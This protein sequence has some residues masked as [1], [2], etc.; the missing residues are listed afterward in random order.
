MMPGPLSSPQGYASPVGLLRTYLA[1]DR[2][3]A[4]IAGDSLPDRTSASLLFVDIAGFTRLTEA[5][6]EGLGPHRGVEELTGILN[7]VYTALVA[8]IHRYGGSVICFIG[9]AL[10]SCFDQDPGL[11][12]VACALR[13]QRAMKQ[14]GAIPVPDGSVISPAMKAAVASGPV[15][16]FLIGDP[17]IRLLDI[18]AGA[19]VDRV[20]EAEHIAGQGELVVAPE[21][22]KR[23]ERQLDIETWR[24]PFAVVRG[25]KGRVP[26]NPWPELPD[27]ALEPEQTRLFLLPPV[28]E[29]I[30]KGAGEF[31]AE[32]RPVV[33]LF[34]RF[35]GIDYD[36]DDLAG[37]KLGAFGKWVQRV[38]SRYGGHVLLL[39]T[40]DKGS[41]L[42]AVFGALA[43]HEND[44]ERAVAAA[45]TLQQPPS[46]LGFVTSV[47]IGISQGMARVG[48]YGGEARRTYGTLGHAVNLAAR[49]MQTA[50]P[51]EIRCSSS[52]YR[53][54][55]N[56][57]TFD[58]LPPVTVKG[59]R[60]PL[61]VYR[62][63]GTA[64]RTA[65]QDGPALVGRGTERRIIEHCL[66]N[67]QSTGR[68][69]LLL[70]G[71]AGM[72]KSRLADEIR[73]LADVESITCLLGAADSIEPHTPYRAW[74]DILQ[75]SLGLLEGMDPAEQRARARDRILSLDPTYVDRVALLNDV[76]GLGLPESRLTSGYD[77]AL[78]KESLAALVGELLLRETVSGRV[79]LIVEDAHWLDSLSW[80]LLLSVARSLAHRPLLLVVTHRP[81]AEPIPADYAAL[82]RMSG[83]RT[84]PLESLPPE[85]TLAL[86]ASRVGVAPGDLPREVASLLTERAAGNPFFAVELVGALLDRGLLAVKANTCTVVADAKTLGDSVPDSLEGVVLSRLD[87][88]PVEEQLTMRVAAVVGRS[89]LVRTLS[90]VYPRPIA[91]DELRGHLANTSARQLTTL[92]AEDPE[93]AYAFRH[94]ITQQVAYGTLLFAQRRE[95]HHDIATWYEETYRENLSPHHPL[96]AFHWNRAGDA[97][98][99]CRHT[100][101]AG[102]QAAKQYA[103]AEA[104]IYF[105]R[106]LELIDEMDRHGLSERRFDTLRNLARVNALL[107]SVEEERHDLEEL[108][109]MADCAEMAEQKGEVGLLWSDFHRRGGRF[110]EALEQAESALAA[111]RKSTS[112]VGEARAL[113]HAGS[114]LEGQGRFQD[115]RS[116]VEEALA[117]FRELKAPEGEAG[118]LKTLGIISARL[119]EFANA[120]TRFNEARAI[121][122]T[123][124]DKKGEADILGNLGAV[125]YHLG[126]YDETL[127]H[128][129]EAQQLFQEMGSR[130]GA[131][132]C[133]TNLGNSY[134]ALGAFNRGLEHHE[135]ALELYRQLEDVNGC[136]D[137]YSNLGNSH[138]AL[139]V[140][141]HPELTLRSYGETQGLRDAVAC[142]TE[143]LALRSQIE[144]QAGQAVSLFNLGSARL[145]IGNVEAAVSDL[146]QS[147]EASDALG[148]GRLAMRAI[149]ALARASLLAGDVA[150]A[151]SRSQEAID[152]LG[153]RTF[154][155]ADEVHFTHFR[156]LTADGRKAQARQHLKV[157]HQL[158]LRQAEAI[159][160]ANRRREY[161]SAYREI[162]DAVEGDGRTQSDPTRP[163]RPA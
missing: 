142:Y 60:R 123:L 157:A 34:L 132:K 53:S 29:R 59:V 95:L 148:L 82:T 121:F 7:L 28:Y 2:R 109:S 79:V 153:S 99:E 51:G 31:L 155:E 9:D 83:T 33:V 1:M 43:A 70:E 149:S 134:N 67:L 151:M 150:G 73:R 89:F 63:T 144:S 115:A 12:A 46:E 39:T 96:L 154:P 156:V 85:E 159:R 91:D 131:A 94:V 19:T 17:D 72:G 130:A 64:R 133:L 57:W 120:M 3:R 16:R 55:K 128:T 86:A 36:N 114:A 26:A 4:L 104:K 23:H 8:Q 14:F 138:H 49:L 6:V 105:S 25:L 44:C 35:L 136:A 30:V 162:L 68:Q 81:F 117:L 80:E 141:G 106:A 76:L 135:R 97:E 90:A 62:P 58:T 98:N 122:H 71:E 137:S 37:E 163:D 108:S 54:A 116:H 18:L 5:L 126:K 45:I 50:P 11:R 20:A 140:G 69:I 160:D 111:F 103:N 74:R 161:L 87:R 78:R 32:L 101:L 48:A 47:Q 113:T 92:E 66:S 118:S 15:R 77:P 61:A 102:A 52:A 110:A 93:P 27:N 139:A 10:L 84:L 112:G 100:Q 129:E 125:N 56:H 107:G 147:L 65:P 38:V 40:A 42:Y 13:M 127:T 41:H 145:C 22:A 119:G 75:S 88:L 24:D 21:V 146:K 158:V 143:A 124:G 152:R